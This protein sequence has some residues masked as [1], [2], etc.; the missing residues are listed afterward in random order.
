MK[1]YP[2]KVIGKHW[3]IKDTA[4]YNRICG[5]FVL[6]KNL[7]LFTKDLNV[8]IVARGGAAS[9][10]QYLCF[11]S[12]EDAQAFIKRYIDRNFNNDFVPYI[13]Q[14]TSEIVK[15]SDSGVYMYKNVCEWARKQRG[16]KFSAYISKNLDDKSA[17]V[18]NPY[19]VKSD[20][21]KANESYADIVNTE[22]VDKIKVSKNTPKFTEIASIDITLLS[23]E[24]NND[25]S[26]KFS[27]NNL[28]LL[29]NSLNF[30]LY[31]HISD[32]TTLKKLQDKTMQT[33]F[34]INVYSLAS[35]YLDTYRFDIKPL[36]LGNKNIFN[37]I[38]LA[39]DNYRSE[40]SAAEI[41]DLSLTKNKDTEKFKSV[42]ID[43]RNS[44]LEYK[45]YLEDNIDD[46][47]KKLRDQLLDG[48]QS[49]TLSF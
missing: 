33:S 42:I 43:L 32:L 39:V 2:V 27:L 28:R 5:T 47:I 12:A 8:N 19:Y 6:D 46:I 23:K 3:Q 18:N 37:K 7:S 13:A 36:I 14:D 4:T 20:T 15:I 30:S 31:L 26:I 49:V 22:L 16:D 25:Y 35:D 34:S 24:I 21:E 45:K 38:T 29:Q 9:N 11:L 44:L 40:L 1:N 10:G 41:H 48:L 17:P